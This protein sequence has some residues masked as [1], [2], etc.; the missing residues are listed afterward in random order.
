M[1]FLDDEAFLSA[2][3]RD[4]R[5]LQQWCGL[6][7]QSA[8]LDI[9]CGTG[10]LAIGLTSVLGA[11]RNY[12]GIDV[13]ETAI[14]WCSRFITPQHPAFHF[15]RI[16]IRNERYNPQGQNISA[17]FRL[18]FEDA[19]FDV[20]H[21][22]SVFSHMRSADVRAYLQEFR[23]LLTPAGFVFLTAFVETDVPDE[24]ENPADYRR[25]WKGALHCV[26]FA[27]SFFTRLVEEAHLRIVRHSHNS[28]TD[29]QSAFVL[30][31]H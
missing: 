22:Y 7:A 27:S 13:N 28:E 9:G 23:R 29:G 16:N 5:K 6:N 26:R 3:E 20:I 19:S 10:R 15:H 30:Q 1:H 11:V 24:Q 18:P 2:G 31:P 4:V 17:E 21:L 12:R 8:V 25:Q 14:D